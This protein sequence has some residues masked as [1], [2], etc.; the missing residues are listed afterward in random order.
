MNTTITKTPQIED[1]FTLEN[2]FSRTECKNHIYFSEVAGYQEATVSLREGARMMK[3]IRNNDRLIY[4]DQEL[5]DKL[6]T[7]ILPFLPP[8]IEGMKPVGLNERFRFYRYT[9]K[10]R[11]NKHRD[12]RFVRNE[13]EESRLTFLIYLNDDFQGG[14]TEFEEV[15]IF[16]KAGSGLVFLH[17]LRHKGCPVI[18]GTKYV[19]RTDV[20]YRKSS[21]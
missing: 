7:R 11:F 6:F 15:S 13:H 16:P 18:A 21:E 14:E 5:A 4:T 10:Q 1:V 2:F 19:L 17:E 20:M 12:G 9:E 8:D 3:G